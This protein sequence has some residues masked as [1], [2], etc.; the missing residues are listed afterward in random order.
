MKPEVIIYFNS[1][2]AHCSQ[3]FAGLELLKAEGKIDLKYKLALA[4]IPF[5]KLRISY[6]G[7]Q[8]IFDVADDSFIDQELMNN[9]DFYVKRMLLSEKYEEG[10]KLLPFG[11]NYSVMIPNPF[12]KQ[13]WTKNVKL[14]SYSAK[15]NPLISKILGVNDSIY[16]VNLSNM[17]CGPKRREKII[18]GTR[19]WDPQNNEVE[20]KKNERKMLNIQR[21]SI[22]RRLKELYKSDFVGGVEDGKLAQIICP[23]VIVSKL[24]SKKTNY[25]N[26]LKEGTIGISNFGLEGSI[27]WK[28]AEYIAHSMAVVSTPIDQY[29]IHGELLEGQNY[30]KFEN[31]QDC[32]MTIDKLKSNPDLKWKMQC[33]NNNYYKRFLH[34]K[35]K[36]ELIFNQIDKF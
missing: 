36:M 35:T 29:V 18:F 31:V 15:Y 23:D 34:P 14:L 3:I 30:L 26:S 24:Q 33:E 13:M 20:W 17:E 9:H 12:L 5:N 16:N 2:I 8:V 4:E 21:I 7:K 25:L 10:G 1:T 19:L 28:F 27:G 11:L 6:R 32:L 22:I